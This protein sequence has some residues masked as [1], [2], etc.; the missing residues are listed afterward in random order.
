MIAPVDVPPMRS[1]ASQSRTGFARGFRQQR[2]QPLEIGERDHAPY[3]A[4]VDGKDAFGTRAE[5]VSVAA[6]HGGMGER[7]AGLSRPI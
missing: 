6:V 4:A 1:N 5:E 3:A 2:L 7:R